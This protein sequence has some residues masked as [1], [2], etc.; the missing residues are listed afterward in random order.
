M[1][2]V[3]VTA[4]SI[5]HAGEPAVLLAPAD[6]AVVR[7]GF[8]PE[9]LREL[10]VGLAA[11]VEPVLDSDGEGPASGTL[12]ELH[13]MVDPDT[14]LVEVVVRTDSAP[15]WLLLGTVVRVGLVVR[16][17]ADAVLVPRSALLARGGTRGV[18]VVEGGRARWTPIVV[19]IEGREV[20]EARSG[21]AAG[22]IV[23]TTGRSV[24]G[25]GMEVAV[26]G[27]GSSP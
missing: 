8:E 14:Q 15:A 3:L 27:P 12:A 6:G 22:A 9:R 16:S 23:V 19:G 20:V 13:R 5:V 24:V 18:F 17:A 4:G 7:A 26:S 25:D 11:T 1:Q 21:L 2:E 10:E